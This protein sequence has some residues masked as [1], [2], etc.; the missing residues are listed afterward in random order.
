MLVR[1]VRMTFRPEEV[2]SFLQI[3]EQSKQLIRSFEGC[4]HLE[5]HRDADNP[6]VY[7]TYSHWLSETHLNAY[8]DSELFGKTWRATKALF[9][10]KPMA[11]SLER[12]QLVEL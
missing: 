12:Q 3:F 5:L 4:R 7:Y 2:A 1:I 11:F 6:A 9:A 8:R 10:D